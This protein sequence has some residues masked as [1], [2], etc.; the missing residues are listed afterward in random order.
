MDEN[1]HEDTKAC[2]SQGTM[3]RRKKNVFFFVSCLD[4]IFVP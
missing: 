4:Q 2:F 3:K 1:E